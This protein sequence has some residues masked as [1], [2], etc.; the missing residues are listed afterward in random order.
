MVIV[1]VQSELLDTCFTMNFVSLIEAIREVERNTVNSFFYKY[2]Q[3][4]AWKFIDVQVQN[5]YLFESLFAVKQKRES[6]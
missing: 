2:S 6:L 4:Y 3:D 1:R 5:S